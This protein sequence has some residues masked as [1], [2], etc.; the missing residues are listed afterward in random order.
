[1]FCREDFQRSSDET[2][3]KTALS[4]LND[5]V[6]HMQQIYIIADKIEN[7]FHPI[8]LVKIMVALMQIG[9]TLSN[10]LWIEHSS[11]E[12]VNDLQYLLY[13]LMDVFALNYCGQ[14]FI[15]Q[16]SEISN[17]LYS[18]NWYEMSVVF[19]TQC[20]MFMLFTTNPIRLRAGKFF[21]TS[22]E[23]FVVVCTCLRL[24]FNAGATRVCV[25]FFVGTDDADVILIL[26]A[27]QPSQ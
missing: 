26:H 9:F 10:I 8:L 18:I 1:M 12:T 20:Q 13:L 11:V 15:N 14:V 22:Y 17:C 24:I 4:R 19:Q 23:L 21:E 16:S 2:L 7:L 3:Q 6:I 5:C 25:L 27:A